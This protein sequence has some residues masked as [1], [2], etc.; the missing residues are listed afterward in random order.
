MKITYPIVIT[1][2]DDIESPYFV[3]IPDIS[4]M[5]QGR[6]I[7]DS[8]KMARD[9]IGLKITYLQDSN[10]AIP[11]SNHK[12]PSANKND[13]VTLVSVDIDSYRKNLKIS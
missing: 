11:S 7:D 3:S 13:V 1:K 5:T 2:T 12:L 8:I 10:K 4:G 6:T 9:Y